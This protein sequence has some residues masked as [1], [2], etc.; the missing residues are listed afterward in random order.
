M[1]PTRVSLQKALQRW[2]VD[3]YTN[4]RDYLTSKTFVAFDEQN[5][6]KR[7]SQVAYLDRLILTVAPVQLGWDQFIFVGN[8]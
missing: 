4:K 2:H 5:I 6:H 3:N 8:I 7:Q 1:H